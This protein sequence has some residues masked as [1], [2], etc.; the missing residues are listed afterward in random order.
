MVCPYCE[1]GKV[2]VAKI[3]RN[4]KK[5]HLCEECDTVWEGEIDLISG[6]GFDLFMKNEGCEAN[7]SELEV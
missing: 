6:I 4:G 2:I 1:Q 3:K 7:W 5:I